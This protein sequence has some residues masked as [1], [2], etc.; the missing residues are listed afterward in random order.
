MP[1]YAYRC[2]KCGHEFE[3]FH[4]IKEDGPRRCP[5]CRG[6]VVRVP[7]GGAGLLFRGSG[8]YVTDYR[9]RSY[10]EAAKRDRPAGDS[11][12]APPA[13]GSAGGPGGGS[14]GS[15]RAKK[16]ERPRGGRGAGSGS[17]SGD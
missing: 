12:A 9:S 14:G 1:T 10:R 11:A 15:G 3:L 2:K 16:R 5:K 13:G 17:A 6:R 4:G 8:F 7:A